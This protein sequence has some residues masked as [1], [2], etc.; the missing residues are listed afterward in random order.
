MRGEAREEPRAWIVYERDRARANAP[1]IEL[2][3]Q[4]LAARGIRSELR[5]AE[6]LA[7]AGLPDDAPQVA[8]MRC[9]APRLHRLLEQSGVPCLNGARVTGIANDKARSYALA[10]EAGEPLLPFRDL[11]VVTDG[12]VQA[13]RGG[14]ALLPASERVVIK[15]VDGHGGEG[16]HLADGRGAADAL[17][18][19]VGRRALVQ[20]A[21]S[22]LG[23][24]VRAYVHDG[25]VVAA[26]RRR[27]DSDFRSNFCLGGTAEPFDLPAGARA[28]AERMA[29]RLGPGF[30]GIDFLFD[31]G[32]PD[33]MVFNEFEDPVGCRMLYA[34]TR[35]DPAE[36]IAAD[37]ARALEAGR[38][39]TSRTGNGR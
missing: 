35:I 12:L 26:M 15:P 38:K 13:V 7:R 6:D 28:R 39:E 9:S 17:A 24:D 37:A 33:G 21:A 29:S 23:S 16:V 19:L 14:L 11:G 4:S 34:R 3:A 18:R 27:S 22:R 31:D 36:I 25:A 20:R 1:F 8:L 32:F 10:S 2:L 30:Y 5:H